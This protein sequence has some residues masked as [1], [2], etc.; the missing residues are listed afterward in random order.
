MSKTIRFMLRGTSTSA[1]P[2]FVFAVHLLLMALN[3]L[4]PGHFAQTYLHS[5]YVMFFLILYVLGS[6]FACSYPQI[7]LTMGA[8]RRDIFAGVQVQVLVYVAECW[9][10]LFV[11][12]K[13]ALTMGLEQGYGWGMGRLTESPI[14]LLPLLFSMPAGY[15]SGFLMKKHRWLGIALLILLMVVSIVLST[16]MMVVETDASGLW[17][18]LYWLMPLI[19]VLAIAAAEAGLWLLLRRATV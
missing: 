8:R 1:D 18:D 14:Y 2:L 13:F 16:L 9:L 4:L 11:L 6:A 3:L 10:S 17:G 15:F 19:F 7:A 5:A 12:D